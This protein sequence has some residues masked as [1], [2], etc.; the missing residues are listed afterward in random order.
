MQGNQKELNKKIQSKKTSPIVYCLYLFFGILAA[1]ISLCWTIQ[2]FGT[3]LRMDGQARFSFLDPLLLSLSEGSIS[4]LATG[5]YSLMVLY[6]QGCAVKGNII[7]G[8]RIPF[9]LNFHPMKKDRTF[10]NSFLFNVSMMMLCSIATTELTI[11]TFPT[12]LQN[13]FLG[14]LFIDQIFK[15]PMFGWL[16]SNRIFMYAFCI[17]EII[18]F[19][20]MIVKIIRLCMKSR[21]K[22]K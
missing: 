5:I 16:F 13:S 7:F 21:K 12:Y 9:I 3:T 17:I 11:I 8:L 2:L 1:L 22:D 4:F 14:T 19:I 15:L 6:L 18:T 10:L 20:F